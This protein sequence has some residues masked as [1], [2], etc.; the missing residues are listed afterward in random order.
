[1]PSNKME[2]TKASEGTL[3]TVPIKA[4]V[5]DVVGKNKLTLVIFDSL[6]KEHRV[7]VM[8]KDNDRMK[9]AYNRR[10]AKFARHPMT[11]EISRLRKLGAEVL[12]NAKK[13]TLNISM[14]KGKNISLPKMKKIGLKHLST[15]S[16]SSKTYFVFKLPANTTVGTF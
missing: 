4:I 2:I 7:V 9:N 8:T 12:T 15:R 6:G 11:D 16:D 3:I 10:L 13:G 5:E 14:P 1:M